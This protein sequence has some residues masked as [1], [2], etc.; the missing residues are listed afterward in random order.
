[1]DR[2]GGWRRRRP[3]SEGDPEPWGPR[4][5]PP[6]RRADGRRAGTAVDRLESVGPD[7][8]AYHSRRDRRADARDA[9]GTCR[10][11]VYARQCLTRGTPPPCP[12]LQPG[13]GKWLA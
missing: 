3:A 13:E 4:D 6:A 12:P 11:E 7:P 10:E 8:S 9:A 5:P 2:A 1:M